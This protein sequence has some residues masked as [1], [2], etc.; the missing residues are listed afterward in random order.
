MISDMDSLIQT[1][2]DNNL[3]ITSTVTIIYQLCFFSIAWTYKFDKVTD[4]AGGSNAIVISLLT[5]LLAET[6]STRQL[7]ITL[8]ACLWGTRLSGNFQTNIN[9]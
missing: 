6:H 7:V 8:C 2:N 3:L 1:L 9:N 4:F 5:Y